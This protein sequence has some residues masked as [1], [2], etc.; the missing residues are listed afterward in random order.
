MSNTESSMVEVSESRQI[1]SIFAH[2]SGS[3]EELKIA[4]T[5]PLG[6]VVDV[7]RKGVED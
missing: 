7:S 6:K 5:A 2:R 3:K 1:Q 4:S